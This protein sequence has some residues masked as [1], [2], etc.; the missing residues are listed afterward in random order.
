[1]MTGLINS[2]QRLSTHDGSGIRT[3]VFLKGCNMRCPWCHN[4]EGISRAKSLGLIAEK[5]VGCGRCVAFCPG[6]ALS[7]EDGR[8]SLDRKRCS[9]C[10]ACV[11]E[12]YS[13]VFTVSGTE[14]SVAG[15]V[16]EV[17]KD[18]AF[19]LRSGGG[20]TFSGGEP[21]TQAPFLLE[22]M[23]KL[24][25]EGISVMVETN[26]SLPFEPFVE[27]SLPYADHFFIDLKLFSPG[28]HREWTGVGNEI[29]LENIKKLDAR[30]ADYEIRTP[31]IE[32][33]N[34]SPEE[35]KKIAGFAGSL[36]NLKSYSLV[37]YHPMGLSKYAQFGIE[38]EYSVKTFYPRDKLESLQN[39][40]FGSA[41]NPGWFSRIPH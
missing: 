4:P 26:L 17:L 36:K 23:R 2:V 29:I 39:L 13:R 32:G 9:A 12:C 38:P 19:F 14:Y 6:R 7:L 40:V 22:A 21:F 37:P 11:Q 3:T 15:L 20:V 27:E 31:L 35:I 25:E 1:M 34:D 41:E 10:M 18:R 8:I 30:G 24:K 5:C 28:T 16:D 33:V